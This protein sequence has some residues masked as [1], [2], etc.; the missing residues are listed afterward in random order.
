MTTALLERPQPID[1]ELTR[2]GFL[3][4]GAVLTALLSGC[5][6]EDDGDAV[7]APTASAS[8]TTS[9]FPVKLAHKYG[10]T[11]IGAK[12]VRIVTVGLTE[13][14]ALLALG[15]VPVGTTEFF[16][17]LPGAIQPW[18]QDKLG[19]AAMPTVLP[20]GD[21]IAFE[22]VAALNPDLILAIYS[23]LTQQDYDTLSRIAP[24]VAQPSEYIDYGVPWSDLTLTVGRAVGQ[25]ER[26]QELVDQVRAQFAAARD[27][28]PQFAGASAMFAN[29]DAGIYYGFA[30]EDTRGV[31]LGELG[32]KTPEAID[33]LAGEEYVAEISRER[34]DLLDTDALIFLVA[35]DDVAKEISDDPVYERLDVA[36]QGRDVFITDESELGSAAS[37]QSV[38]SLPVLIDGLV[39]KL[40]AAL[41]GDPSTAIP[42]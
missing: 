29:Y 6:S 17:E 15:V 13:Q 31:L 16:G 10:E 24:T 11:E 26:A 2:R 39:P 30:S 27:A 7:S 40:V 5:A 4:G 37:F 23:G 33:D 28:H 9:A 42:A 38:L 8:P 36:T 18:A 34:A 22:Q 20:V 25:A 41:D 14:D 3:V 21:G 19:G 32:L 1:D 12:P 35:T